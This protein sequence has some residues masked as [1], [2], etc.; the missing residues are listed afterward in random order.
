MIKQVI[1]SNERSTQNKFTCQKKLN[2][3]NPCQNTALELPEIQF[4]MIISPVDGLS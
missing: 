4:V 1:I 3:H 2:C